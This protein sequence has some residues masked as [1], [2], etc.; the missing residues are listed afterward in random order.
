MLQQTQVSTVT[1]YYRRFVAEFPDVVSLASA[2]ID[3][4]LELWSG[5]GYYRRAH[6]LHAAAKTVATAHGGIFPR[7]VDAIAALPGVGRSTAAAIAVFAYG[8]RVP[9]L[10]GNVKRVLARHQGIEGF[11]GMPKVAAQL[12]QHAQTLLPARDIVS[13]TQGL[14]D[15]GAML[16]TRTTP[17]CGDC[18]VASDCVAQTTSRIDALPSPR[19]AKVLPQRAIQVVLMES[20]GDILLEKRPPVGIWAGLW[21]LPEVDCGEDAVQYCAGRFGVDVLADRALPVLQ[22]A[23]THY[24]LTLH[25]HHLKVTLRPSSVEAPGF[26][27]VAR[28]DAIKAALPSPIRKLLKSL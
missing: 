19:P 7:D 25:P 20:A 12:W 11:P 9:I 23:F 17:R 5:L 14:M 10:D 15:L 13:Y 24:R 21:S 2:P 8:T 16:C 26:I 1:G 18:P 6:H 3:R 28:D 22:H 27:W 4:V